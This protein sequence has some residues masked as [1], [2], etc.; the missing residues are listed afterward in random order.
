MLSIFSVAA[1]RRLHQ[2]LLEKVVRLPM[3]FFESHPAGRLLNRFSR[4]TEKGTAAQPC[5]LLYF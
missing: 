1:A 5:I 4:D 2:R 3:R